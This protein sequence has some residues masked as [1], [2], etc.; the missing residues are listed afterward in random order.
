MEEL[1]RVVNN[2]YVSQEASAPIILAILLPWTSEFAEAEYNIAIMTGPDMIHAKV[3]SF[4][5]KKSVTIK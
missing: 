3:T 1:M 4:L 5:L 2:K